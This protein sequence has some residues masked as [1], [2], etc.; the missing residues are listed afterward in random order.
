MRQ[1]KGNSS[2]ISLPSFTSHISNKACY[3]IV[4]IHGLVGPGGKPW[5]SSKTNT[6]IQGLATQMNWEV[7]IIQYAYDATKITQ[8]TYPEEVISSEASTLLQKLSEL[9]SD[10]QTVSILENSG[11]N[12]N[13]LRDSSRYQ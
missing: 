1:A 6:W 12:D 7:R 9:R 8:A 11:L 10:Q 5:G 3:S 4:A 2:K 13:Q